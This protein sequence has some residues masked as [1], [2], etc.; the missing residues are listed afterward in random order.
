MMN[1]DFISTINEELNYSLQNESEEKMNLC[2][3]SKAKN[4]DY[5]LV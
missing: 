3:N 4:V 2:L 5:D 1:F